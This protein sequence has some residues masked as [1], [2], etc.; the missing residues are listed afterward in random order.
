MLCSLSALEKKKYVTRLWEWE[1]NVY[2]HG[3]V[4]IYTQRSKQYKIYWLIDENILSFHFADMMIFFLSSYNHFSYTAGCFWNIFLKVTQL[5]S[6]FI[7][8]VI[9]LFYF[10]FLFKFIP[11]EQNIYL[12]T[13]FNIYILYSYVNN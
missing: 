2:I 9:N 5:H 7:I 3:V 4:D 13:C 1:C 6:R 8:I 11:V 10:F 12:F